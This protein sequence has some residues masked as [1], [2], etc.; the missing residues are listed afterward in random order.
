MAFKKHKQQ[1]EFLLNDHRHS[2][3]ITSST[4]LCVE[5]ELGGCRI[6]LKYKHKKFVLNFILVPII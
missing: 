6:Y 4:L 1:L 2:N 5:A 3:C